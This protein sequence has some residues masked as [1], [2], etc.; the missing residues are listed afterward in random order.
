MRRRFDL[1]FFWPILKKIH[2][3]KLLGTFLSTRKVSTVIFIEG[4]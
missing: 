1:K 4:G 3:G 2:P